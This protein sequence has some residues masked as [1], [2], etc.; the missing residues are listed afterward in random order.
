MNKNTFL[1]FML[2]V[3]VQLSYSQEVY[4][5]IVIKNPSY[6]LKKQIS[7]KGIDLS[8]GVNHDHGNLI[9]E[10]S[11]FDL[12]TLD[13]TGVNYSTQIED[14]SKFYSERITNTYVLR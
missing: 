14:L 11:N 8:C 1:G 4:K 2:F 5:R 7:E 9:L 10:L 6:N 12:K 3:A 13:E